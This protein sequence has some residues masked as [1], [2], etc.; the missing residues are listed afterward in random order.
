MEYRVTNAFG[1]LLSHCVSGKNFASGLV[2]ILCSNT[3]DHQ[4]HDNTVG[5]FGI[6]LACEAK[7]IDRPVG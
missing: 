1:G 7:A 6:L 5:G 2:V 4:L 3:S